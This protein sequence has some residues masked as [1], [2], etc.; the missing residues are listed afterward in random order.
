MVIVKSHLLDRLK[1]GWQNWSVVTQLIDSD[2]HS[3][4]QFLRSVIISWDM[5]TFSEH[6]DFA[7]IF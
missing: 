3:R 1:I 2:F 6:L 5:W 4:V 7:Q